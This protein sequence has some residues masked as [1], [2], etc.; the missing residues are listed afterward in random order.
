VLASLREALAENPPAVRTW[1]VAALHLQQAG[2]LSEAE[3]ALREGLAALTPLAEAQ[4][5]LLHWNLVGVLDAEGRRAEARAALDA[6]L[7]A[8]PDAVRERLELVWGLRE[9]GWEVAA[10]AEIFD[11]GAALRPDDPL[12]P[13]Y[14]GLA[15]ARLGERELAEWH[16]SRALARLDAHPRLEEAKRALRRVR[17]SS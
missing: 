10:L 6:A 17:A 8:D 1:L 7:H 12:W 16:L 14:R 5:F 2:A 13:L 11:A 9:R 3:R 4:A 15:A